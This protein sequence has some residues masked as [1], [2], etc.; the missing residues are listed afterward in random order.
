MA[1]TFLFYPSLL[2]PHLLQSTPY[3]PIRTRFLLNA[4][5]LL[6]GKSPD[7]SRDAT[8]RTAGGIS[9]NYAKIFR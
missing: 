6:S 2:T 3:C 9:N 7:V 5:I 8:K 1:D 4:L